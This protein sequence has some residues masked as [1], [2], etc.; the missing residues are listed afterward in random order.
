MLKSLHALTENVGASKLSDK[1]TVLLFENPFLGYSVDATW[2]DVQTLVR[3]GVST[4]GKRIARLRRDLNDAFREYLSV[5]A[6]VAASGLPEDA[7]TDNFLGMVSSARANGYELVPAIATIVD[8]F[9]KAKA[10][11]SKESADNQR[12][13]EQLKTVNEKIGEFGKRKRRYLRKFTT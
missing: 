7:E 12:L 3:A 6:E 1:E 9:E 2:K 10:S 11:A 5:P 13:K 4:V 8:L